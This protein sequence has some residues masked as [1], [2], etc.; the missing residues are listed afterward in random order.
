MVDIADEW[1][2][3]PFSA[4][5]WELHGP[6]QFYGWPHFSQRWS[7]KSL[8]LLTLRNV[9]FSRTVPDGVA[10]SA[11]P[12]EVV[13]RATSRRRILHQLLN[14]TGLQEVAVAA[15]VAV[16]E[17]AARIAAVIPVCGRCARRG[18][19]APL[20]PFADGD[21]RA[22]RARR[23]V[24]RAG[25][26]AC[27]GGSSAGESRRSLGARPRRPG[28]APGSSMSD[29]RTIGVEQSRE[30]ASGAWREQRLPVPS[31]FPAA[32]RTG[33]GTCPGL[34]PSDQSLLPHRGVVRTGH[35][36]GV[37]PGAP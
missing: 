4:G 33:L 9:N 26:M 21:G 6:C 7:R 22:R 1:D 16:T 13:C 10:E 24:S 18:T 5:E 28:A 25:E 12:V 32:G 2:S 27:M 15:G 30:P 20:S 19:C 23:G 35:R 34:P 31:P 3:Q 14:F 36:A 17:A 37:R 8:F 29:L 11:T